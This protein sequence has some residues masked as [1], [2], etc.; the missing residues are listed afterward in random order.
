M[1]AHPAADLGQPYLGTDIVAFVLALMAAVFAM[2]WQRER[3]RGTG[4]FAVSMLLLALWAALNRIHLPSGPYL[5]ASPWFYLMCLAAAALAV[6][7]IEYLSV[8]APLRR[9][10]IW[11][12]LLPL[13]LYLALVVVVGFSGLPVPRV[14]ANLLVGVSFVAMGWLAWRASRTEPGVGYTV[15]ALAL[16]GLPAIS[17]ALVA[18]RLDPVALRYWGV[19]PVVLVAVA[20]LAMTLRRRQRALEAEVER[21]LEAES[22][23]MRL[24]ASLEQAVA[25]RTSELQELVQ[26]LESFNRSVSHDLRG[27]LGGIA[28]LA[29]MAAEALGR[30]DPKLAQRALP[31]I[32][33]QAESAHRLTLAL[34]SLARV[35]DAE[36]RRQAVD[37]GPLVQRVIDRVARENN[38]QTMPAIEIGS[39]PTVSADPELLEP[40]FANLIGNAVK[41][42]G[43]AEQPRV[44]ISADSAPG[45]VTVHVR[46]N[47]VGFESAAAAK[48]FDPF[49][50]LHGKDFA[51]HGVGLSIVRRAVERHG[52]RVWADGEPGRGATFHFSLPA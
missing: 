42:S 45:S 30:G 36:L 14:L 51:G 21:R 18:L 3:E 7:L 17:A 24:N 38:N 29:R 32:A 31:V 10:A 27:S 35:G 5:I 39:L 41:F 40:V 48:L 6:G 22:A 20:L 44:Q 49:L 37:L 13:A 46:D 9:P 19:L 28:G 23:L 34:L 43:R 52:G 1:Q 11:A 2:L 50:R 4:W 12:A 25:Q 15:L 33:E 8:P 26:G 16:W 47:G